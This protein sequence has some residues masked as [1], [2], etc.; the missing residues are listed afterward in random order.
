MGIIMS[1]PTGTGT[2]TAAVMAETKALLRLASWLSPAFPVGSFSYSSGL[3]TAVAEG[4]LASAEQLHEWLSDLLRHGSLRNDG[5]FVSLGWQHAA[6]TV[7]LGECNTLV[8]AMAGSAG[9]LLELT[10]QGDAFLQAVSPWGIAFDLEDSPAYPVVVGAAARTL[11]IGQQSVIALFLNAAITN[12]IQ[13]AIRLGVLGQKE[14]VALV[15][16]LETGIADIAAVLEN[17][18]ENDLGGTA[19]IAEIAAMNHDDLSPRIFRS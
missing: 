19:M 12:Q 15:A 5:V 4:R 7:R 13:A 10:A 8:I 11:A 17:A 16:R 18:T 2:G 1:M 3:E 9:R 6:D 14:G